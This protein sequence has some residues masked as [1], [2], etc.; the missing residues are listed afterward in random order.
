[1]ETCSVQTSTL[2]SSNPIADNEQLFSCESFETLE[3][4]DCLGEFVDFSG[5]EILF[6]EGQTCEQIYLLSSGTV[7]LRIADSESRRHVIGIVSDGE[8]L[9]LSAAI[10]DGIYEVTAEAAGFCSAMAIRRQSV[11]NLLSA[12]SAACV[13]AARA[14]IRSHR[15]L[16]SSQF[17]LGHS[18]SATGRIA[19]LLLDWT[20]MRDPEAGGKAQCMVRFTQRE[21]AA[22][23]A[24][25]RETVTRILARFRREKLI[26]IRGA[27][28]SVLNPRALEEMAGC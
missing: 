24:T 11:I 28:L 4:F 21:M 15:M 25:T 12:N 18:L 7:K 8:I 10:G 20:G 6:S 23:S 16:S 27:A 3:K 14:V 9:G 19:G 13:R 17:R 26:S 1:M 5:G 22:M 2:R